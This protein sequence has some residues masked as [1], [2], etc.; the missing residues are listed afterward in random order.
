MY[1][2]G[3]GLTLVSGQVITQRERPYYNSLFHPTFNLRP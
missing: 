1:A 2:M 3:G